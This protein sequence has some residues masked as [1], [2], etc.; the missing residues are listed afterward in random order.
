MLEKVRS[1]VLEDDALLI[2]LE[3]ALVVISRCCISY[4]TKCLY[5]DSSL[6][7]IRMVEPDMHTEEFDLQ[8]HFGVVRRW[9]DCSRTFTIVGRSNMIGELVKTDKGRRLAAFDATSYRI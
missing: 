1:K 6:P 9:A 3:W 2:R 7:L 5:D 4:S 8:Q